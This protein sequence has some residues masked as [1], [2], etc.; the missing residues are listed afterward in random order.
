VQT[1]TAT[2]ST[3]TSA[4]PSESAPSIPGG[5]GDTLEACMGFW[6]R[7]THM[8]KTEWRTACTR[9]LN[10]IDLAAPGL[11]APR[12]AGPGPAAIAHHHGI[13]RG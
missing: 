4:S 10:R 8:T 6:D 11:G 13:P 2:A 12:P 9:T 5:G 1:G 7:G 3:P